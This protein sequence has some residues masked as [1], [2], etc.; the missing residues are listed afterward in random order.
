MTDFV[1][2]DVP[3]L[4]RAARERAAAGRFPAKD[5]AAHVRWLREQLSAREAFAE[6]GDFAVARAR[7]GAAPAPDLPRRLRTLG[8]A[9][10]HD[11]SEDVRVM[12]E[13]L[14][15]ESARQASDGFFDA[16]VKPF[17]AVRTDPQ[18]A[19]HALLKRLTE[20]FPEGATD[21]AAWLRLLQS[22]GAVEAM[23]HGWVLPDGGVADWLSTFTKQYNYVRASGGGVTKQCLPPELLDIVGALASRLRPEGAQQ[24]LRLHHSRYRCLSLDAQL[25]DLCLEL[26]IPVAEGDG[27]LKVPDQSDARRDLHR[28]AAHPA[29]GPRLEGELQD[30]A[31]RRTSFSHRGRGT[32]LTLWRDNAALAEQVATRIRRHL[33]DVRGGG[34]AR[35]ADSLGEL[36]SLLDRSTLA[37]LG[38]AEGELGRLDLVGPLM[39]TLRAGLPCELGWRELDE[40]VAD[41]CADGTTTPCELSVNAV[42]PTLTVGS[43]T[44]AIAVAPG[45]RLAETELDVP[46][47]AL[48]PSVRYVGGVFRVSWRMRKY[49]TETVYWAD[50]PGEVFT[51]EEHDHGS[52]IGDL[53]GPLGYQF[54][55]PDGTGLLDGRRILRPGERQGIAGYAQQMS[56]GHR[57]W[58]SQLQHYRRPE[59]G[60][61]ELDPATGERGE[62]GL[63]S[64]FDRE[65]PEGYVWGSDSLSL[66][67]LPAAAH[68]TPLG[69]EDGLAGFRVSC[70]RVQVPTRYVVEGT[71][72]RRAEAATSDGVTRP[73]GVLRMPEGGAE[74]VVGD[75]QP[76]GFCDAAD[77]SRLWSVSGFANA[78]PG[79][80]ALLA[81]PMPPPAFWHFLTP[82]DVAAS[83]ALRAVDE[84]VAGALLKAA[85]DSADDA[86]AVRTALREALPEIREPRIVE[87]VVEVTCLAADLLRR[88]R[89]LSARIAEEERVAEQH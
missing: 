86:E 28:L 76:I 49:G 79:P 10:K 80:K 13:V 29:F 40:A 6:F 20:L 27:D 42:W 2:G 41:L 36:D 18:R 35:A 5:V 56:D 75:F 85:G 22:S 30:R 77:G 37:V 45:E 83:R 23:A 74:G 47:E 52:H 17:A 69:H 89:E 59:E 43:R 64:F 51:P 63:P 9:A 61:A 39:R 53:Y 70:R 15:H 34:L 7:G 4:A 73:W 50:A 44:R 88:R 81:G 62:P 19:D 12:A 3:E 33:S 26:D 72:G 1:R 55:S 57:F 65:P 87:G 31:G 21:G 11:P 8:K 38:W 82:R 58:S 68:G 71:D 24:P 14:A 60:W 78:G 66:V 25:V 54:A 32:A 16:A 48:L 46:E 84:D 67:R